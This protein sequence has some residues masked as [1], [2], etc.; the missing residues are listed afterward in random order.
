MIS[1]TAEAESDLESQVSVIQKQSGRFVSMNCLING[2]LLLSERKFEKAKVKGPGLVQILPANS[3]SN[4]TLYQ[5]SDKVAQF[6][7][8]NSSSDAI[9]PI[10]LHCNRPNL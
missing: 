2:N 8:V 3:N 10:C 9:V 6:A 1:L 5:T 7:C 4:M